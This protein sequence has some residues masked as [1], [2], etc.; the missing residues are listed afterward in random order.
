MKVNVLVFV[1]LFLFSYFITYSQI[2][3]FN[4]SIGCISTIGDANMLTHHNL[5][6]VPGGYVTA[7]DQGAGA[8]WYWDLPSYF[9]GNKLAAY[10]NYL[11]FDMKTTQVN[12]TTFDDVVFTGNGL[13]IFK[14]LNN[15]SVN[16]WTHY[17]VLISDTAGWMKDS[18]GVLINATFADFQLVL[19]SLSSIRIRGEFSKFG[20][21]VG[22]LDNV[23]LEVVSSITF[24]QS[25]CSL[26]GI[27]FMS[28]SAF[29]P[30]NWEWQFYGA[31]TPVSYDQNPFAISYPSSGTYLVS[32]IESNS[33]YSDTI[34]SFITVHQTY[35]MN[36]AITLCH[37]DSC[38]LPNGQY[39]TAAGVYPVTLMS[40][41]GCDSTVI[42]TIALQYQSVTNLLKKLCNGTEFS[43]SWGQVINTPG[44]YSHTFQN[45]YGCDSTVVYN[46][47]ASETYL[48]ESFDTICSGEVYLLPWGV[49]VT[50][51]GTYTHTYPTVSECDSAIKMHVFVKPSS[52]VLFQIDLCEG[53]NYILPWGVLVTASGTFSKTYLKTNGCDSVVTYIIDFHTSYIQNFYDSL[54]YGEFL[55]LPDGNLVNS[56][57]IYTTDLVSVFG[58]DSIIVNHVYVNPEIL[59]SVEGKNVSCYRKSDGEIKISAIG[60]TPPYIYHLNNGTSTS[61]NLFS[62]LNAGN[63]DCKVV[64]SR[65]CMKSTSIKISQPDSI[66][67]QFMQATTNVDFGSSLQLNAYS[68]NY[69]NATIKWIPE[70]FLSCSTCYNPVC[71]PDSTIT[72]SIQALVFVDSVLC[73]SK[74]TRT[75]NVNPVFY[76]PNAFTPNDDGINDVFKIYGVQSNIDSCSIS[77]FD[78]WGK[79]VFFSSNFFKSVWDGTING[80]KCEQVGYVYMLYLKAK[81]GKE[82]TQSGEI[83]IIR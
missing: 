50:A 57:G 10:N 80:K 41:A 38:L 31:S 52:N 24:S 36:R 69:P 15:P 75:I 13:T 8:T 51:S 42:T 26:S 72:Y 65:G 44:T 78:R 48:V 43:T 62:Q 34:I 59:V 83:F 6:G 21:D 61:I 53:S 18:N 64:D 74:I 4:N 40:S 67:I 19:S 27:N 14:A 12:Q 25:I 29:N 55:I 66:E 76:L 46:V 22:S 9:K 35:T 3:P 68:S 23:I 2:Q 54:C 39:V 49:N 81:S 16:V 20:G 47:I 37:G 28:Q 70:N 82:I 45:L 77:I 60:G 63:Y 30:T 1:S 7:H 17:D 11:R 73:E 58:C 71:S 32:L 5:G 33:C 79:L 56:S